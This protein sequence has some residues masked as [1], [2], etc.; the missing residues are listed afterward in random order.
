MT[1]IACEHLELH[2][3]G[4]AGFRL[5]PLTLTLPSGKRTALIGPSG[6]GKTTLL[7]LI[8]GL[9][10]AAAGKLAFA[11]EVVAEAGR[12]LVPPQARG[13]GFVFQDGALWPHLHALAHLRFADPTLDDAA[14]SARLAR[15][16]LAGKEHRRPG[17]LSGGERQRLALARALVGSPRILLLDEPLH[18][19]DVHLRAELGVLIRNLADEAGVTLVLVTH[20]RHEALAIAD[21]AV[22]LRDGLVVEQ[23]LAADLLAAPRTAFTA[24]FLAGAACLTCEPDGRGGV[25]TPFGVFPS[26]SSAEVQLAVLTGDATIDAAGPA[27]ARVLHVV[28][29]LGGPVA[30]V[31]L[32]GTTLTVAAT[33]AAKPG[34]IVRLR[35]VG[36]PRLLPITA[37]RN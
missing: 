30:T 21:H 12:N 17:E 22:V 14:A 13:I 23:G 19:V 20:D 11:G 27:E 6:C 4:L 24:A 1:A 33:P 10:A 31:Q 18:S 3:P 2:R 8:A 35:L 29:S 28:P 9:E 25:R 5:G 32:A 16:G 34:A 37:P 15:V 7:R 36:E 26:P